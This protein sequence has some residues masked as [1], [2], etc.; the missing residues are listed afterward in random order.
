MNTLDIRVSYADT[1]QMGT[2]YYANYYVYF[3]RGRTEWL[4]EKGMTYKSLEEKQIYLP[5]AESFCKY[6]SP[7]KYDEV[8]TVK[9]KLK[10]I[11]FASIV[12]DYE[13]CCNDRKIVTGS[14]KHPFV[15]QSFK[16]VRI[17]DFIKSVL[18][19]SLA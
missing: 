19:K 4:R 7:A 18:N 10:E 15:N 13:I 5:V 6:L 14:T 8:I 11:G 16:P 12:F 2:V 17:P 1:D 9:T 3:E